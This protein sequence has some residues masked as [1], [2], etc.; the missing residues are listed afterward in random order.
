MLE[1]TLVRS[2]V[3]IRVMVQM[4]SSMSASCKVKQLFVKLYWQGIEQAEEEN[5]AL[6]L[7]LFRHY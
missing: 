3:F 7:F 4:F 6:I 2:F 5:I 1:L